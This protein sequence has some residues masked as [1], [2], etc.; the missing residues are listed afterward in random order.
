MDALRRRHVGGLLRAAAQALE[1][2][3][4]AAL[5]ALVR[6]D[7]DNARDAVASFAGRSGEEFWLLRSEIQHAAHHAAFRRNDL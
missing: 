3:D 4:V 5:V 1:R 7:P 2:P 6:L